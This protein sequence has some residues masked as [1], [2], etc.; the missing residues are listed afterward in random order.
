MAC[1]EVPCRFQGRGYSSPRLTLPKVFPQAQISQAHPP[2]PTHHS[3]TSTLRAPKSPAPD[4]PCHGLPAPEAP[5]SPP[6][7]P[8]PSYT[9][10][11]I[12]QADW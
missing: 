12:T 5:T 8:V 11:G 6:P 9:P 1:K 4:G 2:P 7:L 10:K 3:R